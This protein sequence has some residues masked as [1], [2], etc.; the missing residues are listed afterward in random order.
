MCGLQTH[1]WELDAGIAC[2]CCGVGDVQFCMRPPSL[3]HLAGRGL[4]IHVG[5][6]RGCAVNMCSYQLNLQVKVPGLHLL[7]LAGDTL[8]LPFQHG[9]WDLQEGASSKCLHT[10]Q[11]PEFEEA[12]ITGQLRCAISVLSCPVFGLVVKREARRQ[13]VGTRVRRGHCVDTTSV[14]G[15][16]L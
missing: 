11:A 1:S 16:N 3:L 7:V 12:A 8:E 5:R 14:G 13:Q 6:W 2:C 10:M 15:M 4:G 9:Y